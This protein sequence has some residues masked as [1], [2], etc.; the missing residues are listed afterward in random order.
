MRIAVMNF[1]G[2]VGKTTVASHL[3]APRMPN[4]K[5]FAIESTNETAADLGLDIEKLRGNRFGQLYRDLMLLDTA[6]VDV[7]ASNI[8]DFLSCMTQY[9]SS[10]EDIDRFVL[11]VIASGKAQRET[12]QTALALAQVGVSPEKIRIVFNRVETDIDTEFSGLIGFH[13][14]NPIFH[15][16]ERVAIYESELFELLANRR[17][18][19]ADVVGDKTDYRQR[20]RELDPADH[21]SR[22]EFVS[23]RILQ[24]LA[25]PVERQFAT[26]FA[27]LM[28]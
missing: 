15:V 2:S 17:M 6:I 25:G 26:A 18:S 9:E 12:I 24:T 1:S 4:A 20:L 23:R 22:S 13:A 10:H 8:E 28:E 19:L 7:G 16:D 11:P 21:E 5:I 27:A 14:K 3:L